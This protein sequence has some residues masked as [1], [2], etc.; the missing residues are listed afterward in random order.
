MDV[1]S[2]KRNSGSNS[3]ANRMQDTVTASDDAL[4]AA[5]HI[6]QTT[7][8]KLVKE[9]SESIKE[10]FTKPCGKKTKQV[11]YCIMASS[12]DAEMETWLKLPT[13]NITVFNNFG[14]NFKEWLSSQSVEDLAK[15]ID[16]TPRGCEGLIL[17][18]WQRL[19]I[20]F[21]CKR[22][23]SST[24][25][26]SVNAEQLADLQKQY[27]GKKR[28]IT[29]GS[30]YSI[31]EGSISTI[32]I[33]A[34][35]TAG[36][37]T[38]TC[39]SIA[40][41]LVTW[42]FKDVVRQQHERYSGLVYHGSSSNNV[43]R[44]VIVCGSGG[45]HNHWI[46][47][48][49]RILGEFKRMQPHINYNMWDGQSK[50][51]SVEAANIDENTVTFW[52]LQISKLNEE[53]RKFPDID[54][55]VVITDEMTIDTPREKMKT[56]KSNVLVRLLPQATP[57][58]LKC[59]TQGCTSW[60]KEAFDGEILSPK[61]LER[62]LQINDFKGAQLCM[63]QYCK[64]MQYMP[65]EFRDQIR[66]DL[67][68]L[69][70]E[71]MIVIHVPSRRGTLASYISDSQAD[72]V[73]AS[74]N[75]V[76]RSKLPTYNM[77]YENSGLKEL[78][79]ILEKESSIS[80]KNIVTKIGEI[81][82]IDG[83]ALTENLGIKR[84]VERMEEFCDECPICCNATNDVKMMTCCSYC[85]C[86]ECHS[87]WNKCAFC[88]KPIE[89]HVGITIPPEQ[90]KEFSVQ[91]NIE[92]TIELNTDNNNMQM[93]NLKSVL[94]SLKLHMYKRILLMVD[95]FSLSGEGVSSFISNIREN[96]E[97]Q[98]YD[99]EYATSGKGTYFKFIKDRFDDI[100]KY[101]EPMVLLCS[102]NE[103]SGVL[104][105]VDFKIADSVIVVGDIPE[106]IGTQLMG[107]VFRP[108]ERRVSEYIPF[109]KIYS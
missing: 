95:I 20:I 1:S 66:L 30:R 36:G 62:L 105:G 68:L 19:Y 5:F 25:S 83:K 64:L 24:C 80:I 82:T 34:L 87:R 76:L 98:V 59:A 46:N 97:I 52:F 11:K 96:M 16:K 99:T 45:V 61:Y 21:M 14:K 103:K 58:A 53:M 106:S 48:F 109:V 18:P 38:I 65:L 88:R 73:P 22:P 41:I 63:D 54:V 85:V 50:N 12:A 77:D 35:A 84:M 47:E 40:N 104:V 8:R 13:E 69:I 31:N 93:K 67:Q 51:Y 49:K 55:A 71:G 32:N 27:I 75:N 108:R 37:K 81:K 89:Q 29:I 79:E 17:T 72:I 107:R 100:Q 86:S 28:K 7:E 70:P 60:L 74:F 9:S 15:L 43:A 4:F 10:F 90:V 42:M 78:N 26:L 44:L 3:F 33:V 92:S 6:L 2:I 57:Q 94:K 23:F 102:N 101:P 56:H 39:I 91:R